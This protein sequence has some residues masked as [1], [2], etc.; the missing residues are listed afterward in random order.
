MKKSLL[1][2]ILA[3]GSF[4]ATAQND[5]TIESMMTRRHINCSDVLYNSYY[6]IPELYKRH[7]DDTLQSLMD[8][9]QRHCGPTDDLFHFEILYHISKGTFSEK[10]F[11]Y[12]NVSTMLKQYA[13]V[14]TP[15]DTAG[16][17]YPRY[18]WTLVSGAADS[19][20]YFLR[21]MAIGLEARNNARNTTEAFLV[22]YYANPSDSLLA[23]LKD[24]R[25][26]ST[27]L[28]KDYL[29]YT[30]KA[31]P[32]AGGHYAL[33]SGI[34]LPNDNLNILGPHPYINLHIGARGKKL[35]MGA[36]AGLKFVN[37]SNDFK[38][39]RNDSLHSSNH[40]MGYYLGMDVGYSIS[41]G[42]KYTFDLLG[43]IAYDGITILS[44]NRYPD[45]DDK[46]I[47]QTVKSLN[48]NVGAG[49]KFWFDQSAYIGLDVKY[50]FLFY[51]NKGGTDMSG[52]AITI[53]ITLGGIS[54]SYRRPNSYRSN[55]RLH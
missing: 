50:N 10:L 14:L 2:T 37:A 51:N 6:L 32:R 35:Y 38:V 41:S 54:P 28:K 39:L 1:V 18:N 11:Q 15:K 20:Y 30:F 19:F 12:R 46:K 31:D 29:D 47:T 43:G 42:E 44:Y 16:T 21:D 24:P 26:D 40:F 5:A 4:A 49:Y 8:Y 55:Y 17:L 7:A 52:N 34:W 53:G 48:L 9:T 33:S 13:N 22:K 27:V 45:D 36:T 3:L 25:Y 23:E